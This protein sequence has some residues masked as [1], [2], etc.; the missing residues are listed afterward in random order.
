MVALGFVS[1][2]AFGQAPLVAADQPPT[3][4]AATSVS[5]GLL[6]PDNHWQFGVSL[7][8]AYVARGDAS[9]QGQKGE[10]DAQA[11]NASASVEIP[12]ND[13]WFI[14]VRGMYH[15]LAL[16]TV[17][18]MPIPHQIDTL[19]FDAGVGYHLGDRWTF[20]ASVGPRLYRLDDI[21]G[22]DIGV[23]AL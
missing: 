9:F 8:Y 18:G 11:L 4:S 20:S 16:G 22:A 19:G 5:P 3:A 7:N 21:D 13:Q 17:T 12:I 23:A 1:L 6:P 14:P 2:S 15:Y 10:S